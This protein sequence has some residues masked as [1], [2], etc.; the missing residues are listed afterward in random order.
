MTTKHMEVGMGE[1]ANQVL[2]RVKSLY[3]HR[4]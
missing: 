4:R 1:L 2:L 3:A